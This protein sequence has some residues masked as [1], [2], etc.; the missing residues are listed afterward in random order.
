MS[1]NWSLFA[2]SAGGNRD[3]LQ[4]RGL[5]SNANKSCPNKVKLMEYREARNADIGLLS[6]SVHRRGVSMRL[7][8]DCG[9]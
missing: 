3:S 1:A 8:P 7:W 5:K 2:T 6:R 4:R 9:S